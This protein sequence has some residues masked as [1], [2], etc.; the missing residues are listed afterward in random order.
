MRNIIQSQMQKSCL[1]GLINVLVVGGAIASS[2]GYAFA[3]MP[4]RQLCISSPTNPCNVYTPVYKDGSH[5][6]AMEVDRILILYPQAIA[7]LK[8]EDPFAVQRLR[9]G[10]LATIQRLEQLA[11]GSTLRLR[12]SLPQVIQQP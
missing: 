9:L 3:Q 2:Q 5:S 6:P 7:A 12:S 4:G 1:R 10:D 8:K 11:P